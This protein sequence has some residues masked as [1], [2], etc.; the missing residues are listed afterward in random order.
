M[1][2]FTVGDYVLVARKVRSRTP[3]LRVI[4]KGPYR[5]V[6][7]VHERVYEVQRLGA[8][9]GRVEQVHVR[10]MRRYADRQLNVTRELVDQVHFDDEEFPVKDILGWRMTD[11][12]GLQL[13]VRWLGY[14]PE[15]D[16]WEPIDDLARDIHVIV[17]QF[18]SEHQQE[19]DSLQHWLR[20]NCSGAV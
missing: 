5:V 8:T 16:S 15:W 2:Q 12:Y 3:K 17:R 19:S 6:G 20:D 13:K 7:T 11:N 10:R 4:W 14:G 1:P 9:E 18:V